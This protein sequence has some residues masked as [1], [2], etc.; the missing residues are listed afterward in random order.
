LTVSA[1]EVI[2]S[3]SGGKDSALALYKVMQG[4]GYRVG[5]LLTT[6]TEGYDRISMHGVRVELLTAQARSIGLPLIKV[7]IPQ[8]ASNE[9]Y[10]E[11]MGAELTAQKARGI[12]TVVF[13]D[14][15]LE[16]LRRYRE[17]R[18]AMIGMKAE[19]PLWKV[20]SMELAREF[21]ALGFQTIITCVDTRVLDRKFCGRL[22]D[23]AFLSD[24]PPGVDPCGENGEFHSF[25][26]AG[27]IFKTPI[28]FTKGESLLREGRFYFTDLVPA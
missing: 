4:N 25:A 16:D 28:A 22:F 12:D 6:V 14:I 15:F 13:A 2:F 1:I 23:A 24:L 10:E 8:Q 7:M 27:P 17:D 19:F 18:L 5:T 3:W 11:R 26:F 9:S 21:I 20:P